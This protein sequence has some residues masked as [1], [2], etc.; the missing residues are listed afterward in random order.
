MKNMLII[1]FIISVKISAIEGSFF[2]RS[3]AEQKKIVA[4]ELARKNIIEKNKE[5]LLK[6]VKPGLESIIA[7]LVVK[8]KVLG[9]HWD[10][11]RSVAISNCQRYIVTGSE[12]KIA[13]IWD[14]SDLGRIKK[15]K[16]HDT[17]AVDSVALSNCGKFVITGSKFAKI[18][19]IS[20]P[21][22]ISYKILKE[23]HTLQ[24]MFPIKS[25]AISGCGKFVIAGSYDNNAILWDISNISN[26]VSIAL[27]GHNYA[28]RAVAISKSG[29]IAVT[30]SYDKTARVW[31]IT[32]FNSIKFIELV[33][34]KFDIRTVAISSCERYVATGSYDNT[35]RIWDI[36]DISN[37][38]FI[39]LIGHKNWIESV[40]FSSCSKFVIS[41]SSDRTIRIW[42]IG[43]FSNI[44]SREFNDH[45]GSVE[46][47]AIS[48][49]SKYI[50]SGSMDHTARIMNITGWV[51]DDLKLAQLEILEN[52]IGGNPATI[53][54][55]YQ[56]N[57]NSFNE[58]MQFYIERYL[59]NKLIEYYL[60]A[61]N[62]QINATDIQNIINGY[63]G[64]PN[65]RS[66][67]CSYLAKDFGRNALCAQ[68][69]GANKNINCAN[70][71]C[72]NIADKQCAKCKK[73]YYCSSSCQKA[74]W[75]MHKL[76]CDKY[77]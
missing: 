65:V 11:I 31:Y 68:D 10:A 3:S 70:L 76:I 24:Y 23:S 56:D 20:N 44:R 35:I 18:W 47:V 53:I 59:H 7:G 9:G 2:G 15:I 29:K 8:S 36:S 22:K 27:C 48:K 71:G 13:Q 25:V 16:L 30:G 51:V 33:G 28:V 40:T 12:D 52:L 17:D 45:V 75:K 57:K 72:S 62:T 5:E 77:K 26:I 6:I 73:V 42:D 19:D 14:I 46:S 49:T 74:N 61:S 4:S 67:S 32:D 60:T 54:K 69:I 50:V 41:G 38:K 64:I 34:H 55:Y 58:N 1:G 63:L 66:E 21:K 43:D 37:I 39:T